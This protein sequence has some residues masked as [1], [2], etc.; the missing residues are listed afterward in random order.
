MHTYDWVFSLLATNRHTD[1]PRADI[2][3]LVNDLERLHQLR[4]TDALSEE[5]YH[6]PSLHCASEI[7][8]LQVRL[9]LIGRGGIS[10]VCWSMELEG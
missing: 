2:N 3:N 4:Q 8:R 9:Q 1:V 6:L 5:E 10:A 7:A